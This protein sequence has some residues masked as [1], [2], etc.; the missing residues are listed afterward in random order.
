MKA[1]CSLNW[2]IYL[3]SVGLQR[4]QDA[5]LL[6][7]ELTPNMFKSGPNSVCLQ[8]HRMA[9]VDRDIWA[10]L[11]QLLLKQGPPEQVL[12][13]LAWLSSFS[14]LVKVLP[15]QP[16]CLL[17]VSWDEE[18]GPA[19]IVGQHSPALGLH[20]TERGMEPWES[21]LI[22]SLG[23]NE[24]FIHESMYGEGNTIKFSG[25]ATCL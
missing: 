25:I 7:S 4:E 18:H 6:R 8:N 24:R 20:C 19:W 15:W 23:K 13:N 2:G 1:S 17:V 12:S 16:L 11:V 22:A 5:K 10:H 21:S 3:I 9:V 14:A